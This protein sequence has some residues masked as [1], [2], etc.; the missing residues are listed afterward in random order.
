M[1]APEEPHGRRTIRLRLLRPVYS[2]EV[3][4]EDAPDYLSTHRYTSPAQVYELFRDLSMES[5]EH[6]VCLHLDSKY[7]LICY[8]QVAVGTL[9]GSL[10]HPREVFKGALLSSAAAVLLLHNHPS[11]D[12]EPSAED[13]EVTRKLVEAGKLLGVPVLDHVI[14]GDGSF[15]S[16]RERG[17]L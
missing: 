3:L 8:D 1:T 15:Y 7:K 16:F 4:R 10:V 9:D 12:P 11:G 6:F 14:I 5:K 2:R 13:Q 17:A